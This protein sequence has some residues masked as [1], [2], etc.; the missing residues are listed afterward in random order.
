[1]ELEGWVDPGTTVAA[2]DALGRQVA[3]AVASQLPETGSFTWTT[4]G[5]P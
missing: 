2:A 1:V 3:A 4:R 5:A